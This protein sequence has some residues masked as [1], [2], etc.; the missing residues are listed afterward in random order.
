M[1]SSSAVVTERRSL[2]PSALALTTV[3]VLC[4]NQASVGVS[5]AAVMSVDFGSE[6]M[7]IGIVS[8]GVPM[9]IV[10]NKESKRKT[11]VAV[12][13]RDGERLIGEDAINVAVRFPKNAYLYFLDLLGKKIDNPMVQLFQKRFP[14]YKLVEDEERGTVQFQHDSETF[15]SPEELL[16]MV[17]SKAREYAQDFSHQP[18]K[19]VVITV[20]AYFNQ[21][22]R[23]AVKN[24]AEL[25]DLKVLQLINS[26]TASALNYGIFR[27]KDFNETS[28]LILLYDMGASSTVATVV[29]YQVVK[30]KDRGIT[31]TNPQLA[32]LGVGYDRTL[33]GL[34]MQLRLRDFLGNAFNNMKKTK[35]DVFTNHRSMAKL[36]KEA[37]RLKNVLSANADHYAQIEGLLEEQDFKLHVTREQ[38]EDLCQDL[39]DRVK[40][41]IEQA[42]S[43]SAITMD[44]ID[45]VI[46]VGAGTRV[47]KVQEKLTNFLKR[48]LGK[49]LNTD[50]AAAMGAVYKGA[51]LSTGFKVKKFLVKDAVIFPVLVDFE[52]EIENEDGSKTLKIIRRTL[53]S[54]MNPY[55]QKKI[56]TFNKHINDFAF[57]VSYGE[58]PVSAHEAAA[59]GS[60]N[61]TKVELTG[62]AAAIAKHT[63]EDVESKGVKAHF[64]MDD[65]G[66]FSLSLVEAVFEK[67]S[68]E[69]EDEGNAFAKLGSAFTKLF[70]GGND[71]AT[72]P[73]EEDSSADE[74]GSN[75][76]NET[77]KKSDATEKTKTDEK[78]ENI[79]ETKENST[80]AENKT[81]TKVNGTS[82]EDKKAKIVLVKEPLDTTTHVLDVL[83]LEGDKFKSSATKL[84]DLN[85]ID[86]QRV[87]REK[88]RNLL[89]SFV[90]D[91][92]DKATGSEHELFLTEEEREKIGKS[93]SE[94]SEW[95]YEDGAD[96]E[97][98]VYEEKLKG[99]KL[100]VK[101]FLDRIREAK[102]RPDA[103]EALDKML[104]ISIGFLESS[105]SLPED[106]QYFT[107]VELTSLEKIVS[108][109]LEWRV[110][111]LDEQSGTP[112]HQAPALS[113]RM[114]ADRIDS[115]DR[116]V[117]YMLNKA[118]V[119]KLRKQREA[120]EVKP[121]ENKTS[122]NRSQKIEEPVVEEP[123]ESSDENKVETDSETNNETFSQDQP[124]PSKPTQ[125]DEHTEL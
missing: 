92:Q 91:M 82:S 52:R 87:L 31:E 36:F 23:R 47:P 33:G 117:K 101:D 6:W 83:N 28:Q 79:K 72:K 107:E 89:E 2:V 120:A 108:E 37:G 57:Y 51:E 18:V 115:L 88:A 24:A 48:E 118:R 81:E 43:A 123:P 63:A 119:E 122:E 15:Y 3:L 65:S 53:F 59:V 55:P 95:L 112:L 61:I 71:E 40:R 102:D 27:R 80:A 41:P 85:N 42:L 84:K 19:E 114:I 8:P 46:L 121:T 26:N 86:K 76:E 50:E 104:N 69:T 12:S 39:F 90:S 38:F 75:A 77:E 124:D 116:E 74:S 125:N 20:P 4:L 21:A 32:V 44:L 29:S 9:E 106:Q 62:V 25:A 16:G 34:E 68:T 17:L 30:T 99:L 70:S 67:N 110:K 45:Q 94:I 22:E 111:K 66:I 1:K 96:A 105:K 93:C 54:H 14:Y 11:P 58:L 64:N 78:K 113:V 5:A 13:F 98:E 109:T 73:L 100:L 56:L 35:T 49:S 10:L 7:K 60:I 103:L 97:K